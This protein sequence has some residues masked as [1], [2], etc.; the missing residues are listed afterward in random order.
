[1]LFADGDIVYEKVLDVGYQYYGTVEEYFM[2][3]DDGSQTVYQWRKFDSVQGMY[4][5]DTTNNNP[6]NIG[7]VNYNPTN[8]QVIIIKTQV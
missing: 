8:G 5:D 4:V 6:M 3:S 1:M 2:I 7:G